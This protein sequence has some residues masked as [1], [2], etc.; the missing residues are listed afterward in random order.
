MTVSCIFCQSDESFTERPA[1][2]TTE[3]HQWVVWYY[4][5]GGEVLEEVAQGG[6]G[7]PIPGG[8]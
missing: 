5:L 3:I 2:F 8:V 1:G 7:C 4:V 6:S